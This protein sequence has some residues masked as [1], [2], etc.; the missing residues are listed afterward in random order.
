[1]EASKSLLKAKGPLEIVGLVGE[2]E[3]CYVLEK[4]HTRNLRK[5][6]RVKV[7]HCQGPVFGGRERKQLSKTG[8]RSNT[9]PWERR[10]LGGVKG[11]KVYLL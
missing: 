6:P 3:K 10:G 5:N 8:V 9:L 4:G 11:R 7:S 1:M 2:M